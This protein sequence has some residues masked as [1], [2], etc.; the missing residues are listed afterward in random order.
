MKD[1]AFLFYYQDWLVGTY[2]LN[3]REKGAYMDLLCYQ[4][5]K[6][7]LTLQTIK[8]ILNGDFEC[9]NKL[10][11]KFIEEDGIFYNKRLRIEKEK[12]AKHITN[13]SEN[14][15]KRWNKDEC[16][17]NATAMPL[18]DENEN[19]NKDINKNI[20]KNEKKKKF[21]PPTEE[22][23]INYFEEK[24]YRKDIAKKAFLY[25]SEME[26]HD[27]RDKPI[28][29]WKGKMVAVWFKDENKAI[30]KGKV[31]LREI[32]NDRKNHLS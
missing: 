25:Y 4:A 28:K 8:E 21:I 27:S 7:T 18:E 14:A 5:D 16:H 9:W 32:N 19:I 30:I 2:F 15:K 13:Q 26:W 29:S 6:G 17:G 11:E 31:N 22:E 23:V 1:P 12:R 3:R 24:G 10:Q 20:N